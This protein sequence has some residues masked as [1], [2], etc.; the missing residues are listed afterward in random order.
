MVSMSPFR[1]SSMHDASS[2]TKFITS[3][4]LNYIRVRHG[5]KVE[6]GVQAGRES[7]AIQTP[8]PNKDIGRYYNFLEI[9]S[10]FKVSVLLSGAVG[11]HYMYRKVVK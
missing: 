11:G 4:Y 3:L 10:W 8:F 9:P 6:Y 5:I 7:V 1:V 2:T